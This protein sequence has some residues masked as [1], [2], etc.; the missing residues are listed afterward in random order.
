MED[1]KRAFVKLFKETAR[2]KNR[3]EVFRDFVECSAISLHNAVNKKQCLEDEY[4]QIVKRYEK[5]DLIKMSHLL[6]HVVMGLEAQTCDFMGSVFM[7]LEL[8]SSA[9]GQFFTP[10]PVSK[11]MAQVVGVP[12]S[13]DYINEGDIWTLQEPACGSGGMIIAYTEMLLEK[14]I[15]PQKA[16]WAHCTDVDTVAAMMCYIQLSLLHIPAEI[17]IGNSLTLE[18]RRVMRTPAHYL[19]FWDSKL[20]RHWQEKK[21]SS[22]SE[23][24]IDKPK[25]ISVDSMEEESSDINVKRLDEVNDKGQMS[26]FDMSL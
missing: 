23:L 17:V 25:S 2:Y 22:N 20:K 26:L 21:V 14:G 5:E 16:I 19:G 13:L 8:G 9:I 12:D 10:Y 4:M 15:N 18:C 24:I 7:E 3:Y 1:H 11:M 6:S